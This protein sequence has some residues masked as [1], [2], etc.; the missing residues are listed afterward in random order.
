M[1][2]SLS[3]NFV[4]DNFLKIPTRKIG[5]HSSTYDIYGTDHF[6]GVLLLNQFFAGELSDRFLS[7][8]IMNAKNCA[9]PS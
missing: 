1:L 7:F 8:F 3:V 2:D 4:L 5:S 9:R 6:L